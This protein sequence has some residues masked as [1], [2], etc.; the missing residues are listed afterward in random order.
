[1]RSRRILAVLLLV[2]ATA[3]CTGV[4][5]GLGDA[6]AIDQT[7]NS[8]EAVF[9][10]DADALEEDPATATIFESL[11]Q[12]DPSV[13]EPEEVGSEFEDEFNIEPGDVS[14]TIVFTEDVEAVSGYGE[15]SVGLIV[16]GE[17]D[18][19]DV[20]DGIREQSTDLEEVEY[21]G[22]TLYT[23]S[24]PSLAGDTIAV[25][26]L[27]ESGQIAIGDQASVESVVDTV[28]G[29]SDA[30]SGDLRDEYDSTTDGAL[31]AGVT[32]FPGD[33][34]AGQSVGAGIDTSILE[35]VTLA[36]Y[37]YRTDGQTV[38]MDIRLHAESASDATDLR[39]V[40]AGAIVTVGETG[41]ESLD[42][43]IDEIE[44]EQASG[45]DSVVVVSYEGNA[46]DVAG[47]ME[48]FLY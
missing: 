29:D 14:E 8:A 46:D 18:S 38:S 26:V 41:E 33:R 44:A 13:D 40:I 39:D 37:S 48:T 42:A 31:A 10:A 34:L 3:G 43:E 1:M 24:D 25:V 5:P 15:Q 21:K 6:G 23:E 9:H 47:V 11:S 7:P 27:D 28:E 20:L 22:H 35:S 36:S 4:V 12:E 19:N 45:D 16:H 2:V 17:F 32:E 30:L